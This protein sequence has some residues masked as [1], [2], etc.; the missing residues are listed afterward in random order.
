[1]PAFEKTAADWLGIDALAVEMVSDGVNK[2]VR[3][4]TPE[5]VL[6]V[7]FSPEALHSRAEMENEFELLLAF[8]EQDLPSA[9]AHGASRLGGP[10]EIEGQVYNW[11]ANQQIDGAALQADPGDVR[12]FGRSLAQIHQFDGRSWTNSHP[13]KTD[14]PDDGLAEIHNRIAEAVA[15]MPEHQGPIGFCH[16]DAWLGNGLRTAKRVVL[17]DFEYVRTGYQV[18]DLATFLWGLSP[19]NS[20]KAADLFSEFLAGYSS[21]RAFGLE[22][23]SLQRALLEKEFDSLTFLRRHIFL[24]DQ[25]IEISIESAQALIQFATEGNWSRFIRTEDLVL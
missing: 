24:S 19:A 5:G 7:R 18:Y 4:T 9:T 23:P 17:F 1:M 12:D 14:L 16:G 25:I 10:R 6:F 11:F 13:P 21:Q 22:L 2:N 20:E 15:S 3:A 8:Q